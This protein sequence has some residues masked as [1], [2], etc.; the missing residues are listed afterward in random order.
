M[1]SDLG[2]LFC[3]LL[4]TMQGEHGWRLLT[5]FTLT[6]SHLKLVIITRC[7]PSIQTLAKGSRTRDPPGVGVGDRAPGC[8]LGHPNKVVPLPGHSRILLSTKSIE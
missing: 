2:V 6:V 8:E 3:I 1:S 4:G 7:W 5:D